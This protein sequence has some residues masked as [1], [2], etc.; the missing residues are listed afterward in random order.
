MS[1]EQSARVYDAIYESIKDYAA[2][3][4]CVNDLVSRHGRSPGNRLLDVACGTGLHD[5]YLLRWY[6]VEGLDLSE[7]QLAIARKRLPA[8]R[9]H[10]ADMVSFDLGQ[11]Y[12]VVTCLFSAI[13]HVDEKELQ[14]AIAAMAKHLSPG[15]LLIVEPWLLP[16]MWKPGHVSA[17]FVDLPDLKVARITRSTRCGNV[18]TLE[19]HHLVGDGKATEHFVEHHAVTLFTK[20]AYLGAFRAAGLEAWRD[21]EGLSSNGRG[22]FLGR[23]PTQ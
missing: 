20:E 4:K 1:Y 8:L 17:D 2:E 21:E 12:D 10:R 3:A 7:A 15:G 23:Q 9:F 18:T 13:G 22:L 16:E 5:Q 6:D 14:P 11:H 19:M